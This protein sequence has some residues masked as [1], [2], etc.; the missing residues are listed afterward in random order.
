LTTFS[1]KKMQVR[2]IL[3]VRAGLNEEVGQVMF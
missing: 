1:V 2:F 3:I